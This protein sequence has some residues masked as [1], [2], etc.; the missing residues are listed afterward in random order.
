MRR[1]K[2]EGCQGMRSERKIQADI[3]ADRYIYREWEREE[4]EDEGEWRKTR[5]F[6]KPL[7]NRPQGVP[8]PSHSSPLVYPTLHQA[9][10]IQRRDVPC[11]RR[12]CRS[13]VRGTANK[14]QSSERLPLFMLQISPRHT[15]RPASFFSQD[16]HLRTSSAITWSPGVDRAREKLSSG[17]NP[18]ESRAGKYRFA[19]KTI[20]RNYSWEISSVFFNYLSRTGTEAF[21]WLVSPCSG[22]PPRCPSTLLALPRK[23]NIY[24]SRWLSGNLKGKMCRATL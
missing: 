10:T 21:S 23:I 19:Y 7:N 11:F 5:P 14:R 1:G 15:T 16:S 22:I 17:A 3:E 18:C 24:T 2:Q 8:A 12:V 4:R 6:F 13:H 20:R 9:A